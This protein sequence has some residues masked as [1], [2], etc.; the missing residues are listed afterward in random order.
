[1]LAS[2]PRS[3]PWESLCRS[4]LLQECSETFPG[5]EQTPEFSVY[6]A[7]SANN[8][9]SK[10][11]SDEILWSR[12]PS[13]PSN[14]LTLPL[15][16]LTHSI[17]LSESLL[18]IFSRVGIPHNVLSDRGIQIPSNLMAELHKL[19]GLKPIT[20]PYHPSKNGR[21]KRLQEPLKALLSMLTEEKPSQWYL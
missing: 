7:T 5:M 11:G 10:A 15:K 19:L 4:F 2:Y 20:T 13:T 1:M 21:V 8:S 18:S 9:P 12:C 6:S 3:S 14:L 16:S 17:L